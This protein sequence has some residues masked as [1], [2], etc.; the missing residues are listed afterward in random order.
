MGG[1]VSCNVEGEWGLA[2]VRVSCFLPSVV[3]PLL[4]Q[5]CPGGLILSHRVV[6]WA[7]TTLVPTS[8]NWTRR[9][10]MGAAST[11]GS[12]LTSSTYVLREKLL[13]EWSALSTSL[14]HVRRSSV[15]GSRT[16][17]QPSR[18]HH[19]SDKTCRLWSPGP[20][21]LVR[22]CAPPADVRGRVWRRWPSG[23]WWIRRLPLRLVCISAVEDQTYFP[24]YLSYHALHCTL[25]Y[26]S[27]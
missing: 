11:A 5:A 18:A 2:Q 16:H 1:W 7:G 10:G 13:L 17:N 14:L 21:P 20:N 15:A 22:I 3:D 19:L 25:G 27:V 8:R 6:R 26:A 9:R 4:T 23:R 24:V 12:H